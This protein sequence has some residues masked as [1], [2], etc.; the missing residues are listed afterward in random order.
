MEQ[1]YLGRVYTSTDGKNWTWTTNTGEVK[2]VTP[3]LAARLTEKQASTDAKTQ[4]Q[5]QQA[6]GTQELQQVKEDPNQ[7][8]QTTNNIKAGLGSALTNAAVGTAGFG[9]RAP[10]SPGREGA[11]ELHDEHGADLEERGQ[12]EYSR[13]S[14]NINAEASERAATEAAAE[15]AQKVQQTSG[16]AGG[17]AAALQRGTKT[18]QIGQVKQENTALRQTGTAL[19]QKANAEY[20]AGQALR[21]DVAERDAAARSTAVKGMQA[22]RIAAGGGEEPPPEEGPPEEIPGQ[23]EP[24]GPPEEIEAQKEEGPPE[25]IEAQKEEEKPADVEK[26]TEE[27]IKAANDRVTNAMGGVDD[28]GGTLFEEGVQAFLAGDDEWK[29]WAQK[30]NEGP[31]KNDPIDERRTKANKGAMAGDFDPVTGT[32]MRNTS[33]ITP[34]HAKGG[35]TGPGEK[36]EPAGVVHKGEY[37]IPKEGVDQ[38]TKKPNLDYVKKIVSDYRVKQ[39]TRNITSAL[40]RRF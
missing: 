8:N 15:N 7:Q 2:P 5:A 12:Q 32:S 39:R 13:G 26:P 31:A 24:E 1:K 6:G 33:N 38:K 28:P 36:Y 19:Q 17:G 18:P 27:E 30:M 23:I 11:A 37:V 10:G 16:A 29:A 20:Q 4:Q 21:T 25:E 34:Q 22:E 35:Y 14:R 40:H 9:V 3:E